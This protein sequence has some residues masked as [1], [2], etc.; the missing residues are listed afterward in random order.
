MN[1]YIGNMALLL[2]ASSFS[3]A[4]GLQ[5]VG[6]SDNPSAHRATSVQVLVRSEHGAPVSG[7]AAD[8]FVVTE[9]GI[10]DRIWSVQGLVP[11]APNQTHAAS[12]IP[13]QTF[14]PA[15]QGD[16]GNTAAVKTYVLLILAPSSASGRNYSL[17]SVLYFLGQ[18]SAEN[19]QIAFLDDEGTFLSFGQSAEQLRTIVDHLAHR[20]GA[21]Q[22]IQGSWMQKA[23]HAIDELGIRPGRRAIIFVSDFESN[24]SDPTVQNLHLLRVGPSAFIASAVQARAAMYT[25]QSSGPVTVT[26]FGTASGP[27]YSES[28]EAMAARL[29]D[30]NVSL[31]NTSSD[32]LYA[33]DQT[34][35]LSALD[36]KYAFAEVAADAAGYYQIRFEPRTEEADGAWHP[37]SIAVRIKHAHTR[38]PQYYLAPLDTSL[39]QIPASMITALQHSTDDSD[40]QIAAHVAVSGR[41]RGPYR[42]SGS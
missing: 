11:A 18:P 42:S 38:G 22:Y 8:D 13:N 35:G 16:A 37:V 10:P 20:V 21:P 7:L 14:V 3:S 23:T 6:Q 5:T 36:P 32:F 1:I 17:T 12:E 40:L 39:Q 34:G 26:P 27:Q 9:N 19:L 29:M 31:G 28:D 15:P 2:L 24:V 41:C 30:E 33:A 4:S 25:V